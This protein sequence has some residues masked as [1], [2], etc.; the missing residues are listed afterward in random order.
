M[1]HFFTLF[2]I[3]VFFSSAKSQ[4]KKDLAVSLSA[5]VLNSPYYTNAHA[6]H[7]YGAAFDYYLSDRSI[8]SAGYFAGK[9]DYFDSI[10]SNTTNYFLNNGSNSEAIYNTFTVQYKYKIVNTSKFSLVPAVGLGMMTHTKRYPYEEGP[11]TYIR[12]SS[13]TDL[14]F[15]VNLDLNYSFSD[16]WQAGITSGLLIHPDY[17]VLALHIGPKLSY[18][19]K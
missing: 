12:Y 15:P 19:I 7:F 14:V 13:W 4:S 8:I 10:L 2:L 11:T 1:K 6:D 5:G 9:H 3:C 18:I 17:P 16:H